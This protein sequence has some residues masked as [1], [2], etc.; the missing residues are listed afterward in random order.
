MFEELADLTDEEIQFPVPVVVMSTADMLLKA[1][2]YNDSDLPCGGMHGKHETGL[3]A[4]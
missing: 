2:F 3:G 1:A 4:H